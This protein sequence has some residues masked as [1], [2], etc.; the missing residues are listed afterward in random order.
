MKALKDAYMENYG[1]CYLPYFTENFDK[2]ITGAM[3]KIEPFSHKEISQM[4]VYFQVRGEG[5][6]SEYDCCDNEKCIKQSKA[7]IRKD[8]GKKTHVEECW[9]DNDGDHECI[10][11]CSQCGKPLN[12]FMTWCE[13]ELEYIEGI[14]LN[15]DTLKDEAF[16]IYCILQSVPSNDCDI[17]GYHQYQGGKILEDALERR[18]KFYQRIGKLAKTIIKTNLGQPLRTDV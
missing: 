12:E 11:T 13:S 10:E 7:D 16:L 4:T 17:S 15:V 5:V 8:Y 9:Y 2:L 18:E 14:E 6:S 1:I 3:E